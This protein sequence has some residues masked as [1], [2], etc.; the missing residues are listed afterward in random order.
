MVRV[1]TLGKV[2]EAMQGASWVHYAGHATADALLLADREDLSKQHV[3]DK[4]KLARGATV[5]LS[6]CDT[7]RRQLRPEGAVGVARAFL[8]AGAGSVVASLWN[9]DDERTTALMRDLYSA[10][11]GG[12]TMAQAMRHAMLESIKDKV[13]PSVW[14]AFLVT[15]A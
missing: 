7:L 15:G 12:V 8:V 14:A 11:A 4:L 3:Q 6:A 2:L 1:A 10:A 13:C 5:V 9:I